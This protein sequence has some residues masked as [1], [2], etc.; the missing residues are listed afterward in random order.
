MELALF[1]N[2][3]VILRLL[4]VNIAGRRQN[5]RLFAMV[6][7]ASE[8]TNGVITKWE[9]T[10]RS[11]KEANNMIESLQAEKADAWGIGTEMLR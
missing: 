5:K 7:R 6:G 8:Q 3:V 10:L 9:E 11:L 1:A 4:M 2:A